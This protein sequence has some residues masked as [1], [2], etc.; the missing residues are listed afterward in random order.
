MNSRMREHSYG[1]RWVR[2]M[3]LTTINFK[4]NLIGLILK[5]AITKHHGDNNED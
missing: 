1:G 3:D 4:N 2:P 5:L